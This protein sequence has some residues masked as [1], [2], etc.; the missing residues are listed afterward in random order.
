[1]AAPTSKLTLAPYLQRW[2]ESTNRLTI[3]VMTVPVDDPRAPLSTGWAVPASPSF[4]SASLV[5]R[6]HVGS[7]AG[8]LPTLADIAAEPSGIALAAAPHARSIFDAFAARFPITK[9]QEAPERKA[10]L[11][12]RKYLPRS[13]QTSHAFVQPRTRLAV[14]D[15]TYRCALRCPPA[16]PPD[17]TPP[18]PDLTWGE[19]FAVGLRKPQVARAMGFIH[20]VTL[21]VGDRLRDGGWVF[22]TLDATSDFAQQQAA[23]PGFVKIFATRVPRLV[24]GEPR[25]VFTAVLFPVAADATAA[26]LLGSYDDVFREALRFDDGFSRI[27]HARQPRAADV[28]AESS[29]DELRPL[30]EA[31]IQLG[32][33]DEDILISQNRGVGTDWDGTPLPE[34][35]RGVFGYR[36][37]IRT[38]GSSTWASLCKV[39]SDG[40]RVGDAIVPPYQSELRVEVHPSTIDGKLWLPPYFTR[41]RTPSLV[42]STPDQRLLL[43]RFDD[44][45]DVDLPDSTDV[46]D[47]RYGQRYEFRVRLVDPTGGGPTADE[48][49]LHEGEAPVASLLLQRFVP[50][51]K[52]KLEA[53]VPAADALPTGFRAARPSLEY[54]AAVFAGAA[55]AESRLV[56]LARGAIGSPTPVDVAV[57][58]PDA[59]YLEIVVMVR[60]PAFDDNTDEDGYRVLYVTHRA[61]ASDPDETL[62]IAL[63]WRDCERLSDITWPASVVWGTESGPLELPTGR[64]VLVIARGAGENDLVRF[65]DAEVRF[66]EPVRLTSEPLYAAPST[67]P[68][69][70]SMSPEDAIVS[71]FLAA[72]DAVAP[73][74]VAA[75]PQARASADLAR[76]LAQ[77]AS[78]EIDDTTVFGPEGKRVVFGCHGLKHGIAPDRSSLLLSAVDELPAQWLH[79]VRFP[80]ERDW[81]F[82][83]L[84]TEVVRV[85]RTIELVGTASAPQVA[86]LAPVT[87]AHA[88]NRQATLGEPD[89]DRF[90]ICYV[91]AFV[92][93][94]LSGLPYE[95]DVRYDFT[96]RLRG[97]ASQTFTVRNHLPVTTKPAQVPEIVSCGHAFSEYTIGDDYASTGLRQRALWIEMK[98]APRDPRD[99]YFVRVVAA[100]PDPMLLPDYEPVSDPA[101]AGPAVAPEPVRVVR[102]G[103]ADDFAGLGA[104]Q[105]LIRAT[106]SDTHYL[107]PLPPNLGVDA[108]E[109]FGFFTYEFVVG[110]DRG[111]ASRPFW[112]TAAARYGTPAVIEGV[113]HP[114]PP[115]QCVATRT[116]AG[117][118]LFADHATPVIDGRVVTPTPPHTEL[119]CV[120]Y[121][122]VMQADGE[123]MRNVELGVRRFVVEPRPPRQQSSKRPFRVDRRAR[124]ICDIARS[125]LESMLGA[126]DLP[127]DAS[128]SAVAIELLPE[129]HSPYD[130]PIARELGNV[131]ILRVSTLTDVGHDCC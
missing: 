26:A 9:L 49:M 64:E 31:G 89:R 34:A 30:Y 29:E 65:G 7:D 82:R 28:N 55:S 115:L 87:L 127:K 75:A 90:E 22:F 107:M 125:D 44:S 51:G 14:T 128:V 63:A 78:L 21:D 105:R 46:P 108:P 103:Q 86:E 124:A 117:L 76:R 2:D 52:V 81:S 42:A 23:N 66:G 33:D 19:I 15:D 112:S 113:Q 93:P 97:G 16:T 5:L 39:T 74:T 57:P 126:W 36:V 104:M 118:R 72:A 94:L 6:A 3:H 71:V 67:S 53:I 40:L 70:V 106:D 11:T 92:P 43:G 58:D 100:A 68:S 83:G 119:W 25:P 73:G 101:P 47:L 60:Q 129:P 98:E 111:T 122:R 1:M 130:E 61:F 32:W 45:P 102:P 13:Y 116:A 121:G 37:D 41:L 80:I 17:V 131:R 24:P 54:P 4:D 84:E 50:I 20:D 85:K 120:L 62:E 18:P 88:V 91:D 123:T 114:P 77:A 35:P 96:L 99:T 56:A 48:A 109:L 27:V 59:R 10:S 79:V 95:V 38:P 12:M 69:L 8:H 110:H